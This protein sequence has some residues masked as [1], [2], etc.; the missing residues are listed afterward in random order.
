MRDEDF[1]ATGILVPRVPLAEIVTTAVCWRRDAASSPI[2][3]AVIRDEDVG[4][5]ALRM[6]VENLENLGIIFCID[7]FND[8]EDAFFDVDGAYNA[9]LRA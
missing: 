6:A 4:E 7:V 9:I 1:F 3:Y 5:N 2:R 8:A